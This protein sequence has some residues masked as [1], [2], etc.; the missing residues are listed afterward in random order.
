MYDWVTMLYSRNWHNSVNQL[1]FKKKCTVVGRIMLPRGRYSHPNHQN[2]SI[3]FVT[4]QI[5]ELSLSIE[6]KLLII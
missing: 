3:C 5:K 6:L 1:Y 2:L 4:C